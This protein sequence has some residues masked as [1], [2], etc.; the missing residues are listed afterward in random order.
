[1]ETSDTLLWSALPEPTG[2]MLGFR[3]FGRSLVRCGLF[4]ISISG[5]GVH[6]LVLDNLEE[7][8]WNTLKPYRPPRPV[9]REFHA[10]MRALSR[11]CKDMTYPTS[12]LPC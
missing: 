5:C 7:F 10:D 8:Q 12:E 11:R 3:L 1:M 2:R 9:R 6:W 4:E